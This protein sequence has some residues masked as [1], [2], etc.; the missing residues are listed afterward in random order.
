MSRCKWSK[1]ILAALCVSCFVGMTFASDGVVTGDAS[2]S[3]VRPTT[4]Y[5]T[6]SNLYVG[7]GSTALIQFA[8]T[9][10][11][12]NGAALATPHSRFERLTT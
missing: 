9:A 7:N 3:S 4:N 12:I 11:Q 5:G 10:A 1:W 2:V 6:L 8:D